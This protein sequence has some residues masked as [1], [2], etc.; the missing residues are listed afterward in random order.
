MQTVVLSVLIDPY[1]HERFVE[2]VVSSV[3]AQRSFTGL[4]SPR[5]AIHPFS[6]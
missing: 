1:N 2:E 3:L 4:G 6:L 5:E